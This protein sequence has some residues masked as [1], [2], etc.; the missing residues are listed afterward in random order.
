MAGELT[1]P[2]VRDHVGDVVTITDAEIVQG[3][4]FL[5]R[6]TKQLTEPAGAAGV[7]ALLSGTVPA[8]D[9]G[10][11][12]VVLSGGNVDL[13]RLMQMLGD[14]PRPPDPPLSA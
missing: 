5:L 13:A 1:Y 8:R 9:G 10:P 12:V 2:L 14:F 4:T 6:Y 11:V 3:M 7:A